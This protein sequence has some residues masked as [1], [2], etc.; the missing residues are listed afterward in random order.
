[1]LSSILPFYKV[2]KQHFNHVIHPRR[3]II[4]S[5]KKVIQLTIRVPVQL[6]LLLLISVAVLWS[7]YATGRVIAV[8]STL[9][10]QS[11]TIRSVTSAKTENMLGTMLVP[12]DSTKESDISLAKVTGL[13]PLDINQAK[14]VLLE[15]QVIDLKNV[16]EAIV[17]RVRVKTDG[18][19]E[20]LESIVRQTG[21]NPSSIKK[22]AGK[23][24]KLD[25]DDAEGGPYIPTYMPKISEDASKMFDSLDEL[26]KLRQVVAN[27]PLGIPIKNSDE[28]SQFGHRI[29]PFNG[30]MAFH[31]G[32][33]LAAPANSP[34]HSTADGTVI[35]AG[36][37]GSYGNMVDIDHGFGVVTRY[38]HL[39]SI[40]VNKGDKV[41]KGSVIG[42]QGSTGRST[43]LHL[44]YEVRYNGEAIN[45]QKFLQT[46]RLLELGNAVSQN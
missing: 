38:G 15:Q 41:K 40:S 36:R 16:N 30:D 43:G 9:E 42:I 4:A 23:K 3:L 12:T 17:E 29:D 19:I 34:I 31:S 24:Q 45:P 6:C 13:K 25:N 39:S 2:I 35:S 1:M 21:L 27:L 10:A 14:M 33:D 46:G 28:R 11:K 32:I 18:H 8:R 44:H 26:Q 20:D 7:S 37:E 22:Q 5:E